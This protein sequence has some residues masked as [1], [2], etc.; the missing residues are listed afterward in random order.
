MGSGWIDEG[1]KCFGRSC[2]A[3]VKRIRRGK[4]QNYVP[5]GDCKVRTTKIVFLLK[6]IFLVLPVFPLYFESAN[7]LAR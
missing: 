7:S 4:K 5:T 1:E 2:L 6:K 3:K